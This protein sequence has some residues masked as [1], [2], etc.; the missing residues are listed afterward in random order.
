MTEHI[1]K[2]TEDKIRTTQTQHYSV[3]YNQTLTFI[4]SATKK[5][6][7]GPESMVAETHQIHCQWPGSQVRSEICLFKEQ[8][9]EAVSRGADEIQMEAGQEMH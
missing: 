9:K 5:T 3:P 2:N 6:N 1:I 4:L 7:S 8:G